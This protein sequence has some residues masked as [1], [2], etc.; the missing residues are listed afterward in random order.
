MYEIDLNE[1]ITINTINIYGYSA[2][3]KVMEYNN[4][5]QEEIVGGGIVISPNFNNRVVT[6]NNI[7]N[8]DN[9]IYRNAG[10]D[11]EKR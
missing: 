6:I 2:T 8:V 4:G 9:A 11:A 7:V 5:A 3:T 10:R 1:D